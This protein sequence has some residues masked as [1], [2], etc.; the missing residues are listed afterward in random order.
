V[1]KV[2][3]ERLILRHL[4]GEDFAEYARLMADPV[5]M[6]FMG[7]GVP[8]TR[9]Q[10]WRSLAGVLGHWKLR[11]YG[12]WALEEKA[13]GKLVGR[14]GLLRPEGWPGLEVGWMVDPAR[15]G[16]GFATE[17]GRAALSF[18]FEEVGADHVISLI[19]PQNR[20]SIRVAEKLGERFESWH[21]MGGKRIAVYGLAR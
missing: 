1:K 18:A 6:R 7:A 8:M 5:V 10:A 16:E 2:E 19:H 17:A 13:T 14:A 9:E 15:W 12:L 4:R 21:E 20:A 11:G 3:T